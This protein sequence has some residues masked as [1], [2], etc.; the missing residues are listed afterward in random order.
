MQHIV[1]GAN[2]QRY[3]SQFTD[4]HGFQDLTLGMSGLKY[5][6]GFF[7]DLGLTTVGQI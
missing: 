5:S 4:K 1:A 3:N 6:Y 2:A 7:L